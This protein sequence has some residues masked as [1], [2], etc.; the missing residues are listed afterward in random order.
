VAG[1]LA[2][3][4]GKFE[5][6]LY[7]TV[8]GDALRRIQHAG[9]KAAKDAGLD[10]ASDKL[11]ADRAMSNFRGGRVRLGVGYDLTGTASVDVNFRPAGLW[12]LAD[13]GRRKTVTVRPKRRGGK[14]AVLTPFGP[15][16]SARVGP[17]RGLGVLRTSI[18]RAQVETPRAAFKQLQSEL[19]RQF[20]G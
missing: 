20:R 18:A 5:R 8:S 14:K 12:K 9:G 7:D 15:R 19:G 17:S 2:A 16:A 13:E 3:E 10:A 6:K 11:G 4:L 1:D